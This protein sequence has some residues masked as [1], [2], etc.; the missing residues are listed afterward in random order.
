LYIADE[1]FFTGSA[2]EIT[3]IATVDRIRIGGGK[4]GP[5][6]RRLQ[7]IFFRTV[8][9]EVDDRYGWLTPV[10][11]RERAASPARAARAAG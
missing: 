8:R 3:P 2:S 1:I 7:E 9:G 5:V 10:P 4:P 11:G 6:T